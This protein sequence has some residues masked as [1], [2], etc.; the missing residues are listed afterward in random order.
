MFPASSYWNGVT[1]TVAKKSEALTGDAKLNSTKSKLK[2]SVA[3]GRSAV[4]KATDANSFPSISTT[5]ADNSSTVPSTG[6]VD[7]TAAIPVT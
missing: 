1:P 3:S 7:I 5:A 4:E 6:K 2:S